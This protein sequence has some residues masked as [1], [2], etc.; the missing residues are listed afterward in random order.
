MADWS[1]S[2]DVP[3]RCLSSDR[4]SGRD[5][6]RR[7]GILPALGFLQAVER[8]EDE[9]ATHFDPAM[10]LLDDFVKLVRDGP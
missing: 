2:D 9:A 5:Q 3:A 4:V 6:R 7:P 10:I 1:E 8:A